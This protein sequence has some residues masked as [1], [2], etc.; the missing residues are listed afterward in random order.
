M[1][2]VEEERGLL[3]RVRALD[4]DDAGDRWV[5][6]R[7]GDRGPDVEQRREREVAGRREAAVVRLDLRDSVESRDL[8][9]DVRARQ[10]R[11]VAPG[12]RVMSHADGA[13]G[14]NDGDPR[15]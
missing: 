9:E 11:D 5:V 8:S 2:Q 4:D 1:E 14:E 3:D 6:E 10:R 12:D 7:G 15:P 13:A